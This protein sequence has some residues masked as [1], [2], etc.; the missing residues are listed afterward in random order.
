MP[1]FMDTGAIKMRI[2]VLSGK[3]GTGKTLV[4]VNLAAAA[5][6]ST[7]IDCD[8][9][10]PNGHLFFKPEDIQEEEISV[11]IPKVD[12]KLCNGCRK[13]VDFCN[14][15]ALAYIKEKLIVFEEVCHSCGGC[16]MLCPEK[17]LTER[18]KVIGKVQKGNSDQIT[19]CTGILNTGEASG[20][21]I[22]KNL[23]VEDKSEADKLTF[24][25]C[26]P[27]SA[28]IVM[29]SI[30]EADYCILVAEPTLFGVH[31]LNMVYELVKLFNKPWGVVL[32]KCLAEENPAEKF[33]LEKNI[34]IL[35]RIPF[36]NELGTLN[37]NAEIAV[38]KN[39]KYRE[40]FSS[41]L[42][43]VTKEVPHETTT[44]P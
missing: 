42:N 40:L 21:P 35:D 1:D 29:E 33:C 12:N 14:F 34:K 39:E 13:C 37:S 17:A 2:A 44:N 10:E 3:G 36:D 28:C 22:I 19:V 32:N 27:G 6:T 18:E 24:I 20:I 7:Y 30:K 41:L 38:N 16:I 8:V 25:D 4:A 15:N 23:L 11:K 43:T 9:E 26:P 31:N 5:I